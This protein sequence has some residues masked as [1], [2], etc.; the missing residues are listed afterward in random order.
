MVLD[1]GP[2]PAH[3][4]S[5]ARAVEHLEGHRRALKLKLASEFGECTSCC[6]S[7][8]GSAPPCPDGRSALC[9]SSGA[10]AHFKDLDVLGFV[11]GED[12]I[13][14]LE[15]GEV[16]APRANGGAVPCRVGR[17]GLEKEERWFAQRQK[18]Y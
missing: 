6:S 17:S 10:W 14:D 5:L 8:Q 15:P 18:A 16:S 9:P 13:V 7:L 2:V 11:D 4:K 1:L 12:R 3:V